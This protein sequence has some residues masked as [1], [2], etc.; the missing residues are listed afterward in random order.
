MSDRVDDRSERNIATLHPR[1]QPIAREFVRR[2]VAAGLD[3]RIICGTRTYAEQD[4]LYEQGRTKPGPIVTK[5]RGGQSNHN[6][7]LAF[8]IG[9]FAS[10]KYLGSSPLYKKAGAIGRELGL[11]WGGDW[12]FVDE[13]HFQLRPAWA[14][15]ASAS[16]LLAGL[17]E[18]LAA[19]RD[20]LAA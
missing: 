10:G 16:A 6:F 17:R 2:C 12:K 20:V 13:P 14:K 3:A 18:R 1:V 11:E 19:K 9:I 5:A 7:G 4:A 15:G 8:D